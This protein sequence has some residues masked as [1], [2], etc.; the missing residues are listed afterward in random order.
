M[1]KVSL[2]WWT[3]SSLIVTYL[4]LKFGL[5]YVSM[6]IAGKEHPLPIPATAMVM[7]LILAFMAAAVYVTYSEENLREFITPIVA[8]LRGPEA[9]APHFKF[10]KTVRGVVLVVIPLLVGGLIYNQAAPRVQSP[11]ILRIQHPTIPGAFERL[12][13]PLR[14]PS[15]EAVKAFM[16]EANLNMSL[17]EGRKLLIEKYME[18][19][20]VLYQINCR[21]CHGTKADGKGEMGRGFRLKPIDFT[22]PGT[23]ATLVESYPFWRIKEGGPGLPPESTPWDSAMPIWKEELKDEEIWKI[24][25]A[26]YDTAGVEPRK[27][28]KLE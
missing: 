10:K 1:R 28:E 24:I 27:P 17:E 15:D 6:L 7:F 11:T 23:I 16:A 18:E 5:S 21:P 26:E 12:Q 2:F 9:S 8:F 19:G 13:N 20:V 22:D 4:L 14:N 3:V 25:M